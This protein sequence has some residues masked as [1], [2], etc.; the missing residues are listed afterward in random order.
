MVL[1][2]LSQKFQTKK[3]ETRISE[4]KEDKATRISEREEDKAFTL[5][6]DFIETPYE[7]VPA[8]ASHVYHKG[9]YYLPREKKTPL[10]KNYE[11]AQNQGYKG[12]IEDWKRSPTSGSWR[13]RVY[14]DW[15]LDPKNANKTRFDFDVEHP[16]RLVSTEKEKL[17]T[18]KENYSIRHQA[19]YMAGK[20][21]GIVNNNLKNNMR[22]KADVASGKITMGQLV[23][24]EMKTFIRREYPEAI[25]FEQNGE[26][27]WG[28]QQPNGSMRVIADENGWVK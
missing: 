27:K 14:A 18:Q 16:A 20:A 7:Y 8:G 9:K 17:P 5:K 3:E 13:D 24:T 6:K 28:I 19:G 10:Q 1:Q 21:R 4:R 2:S 23:V 25:L 26:F 22:M 15:K 11:A 12:S